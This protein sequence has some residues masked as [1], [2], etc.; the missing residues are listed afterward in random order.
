MTLKRSPTAAM[1]GSFRP[2][3]QTK[4]RRAGRAAAEVAAVALAPVRGGLEQVCA[5]LQP[6]DIR[7]CPESVAALP[8][9]A[10]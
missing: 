2:N 3:R 4:P 5:D 7:E 9:N 1:S 6:G 8:S 10:A